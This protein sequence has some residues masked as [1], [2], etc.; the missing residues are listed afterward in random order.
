VNETGFRLWRI[1]FRCFSKYWPLTQTTQLQMQSCID[2]WTARHHP[3]LAADL[4]WLSDMP[5]R[6]RLRLSLTH[7][8]DVRQ[9]Q[10]ATV[11]D[12]AF[13]T[14]GALLWNSLPTDIVACNTLPQFHRELKTLRQS[15]PDILLSI[16]LVVSTMAYTPSG[17]KLE[18]LDHELN[19]YCYSSSCCSYWRDCSSTWF[20]NPSIRRF[21]SD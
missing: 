10:C 19:S 17:I 16:F 8:L 12:R 3:T 6:Q 15:Y 7:Q 21:K 1:N 2:H 18:F 4:R 14:A 5:S 13:A 11:G 9:S 20:R